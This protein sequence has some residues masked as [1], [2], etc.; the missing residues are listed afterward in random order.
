MKITFKKSPSLFIAF[1][2]LFA[3]IIY[4]APCRLLRKKDIKI[5]IYIFSELVRVC[6]AKLETSF[7]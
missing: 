7:Y 1:F 4:T 6:S 2:Y 3:N 5:Q